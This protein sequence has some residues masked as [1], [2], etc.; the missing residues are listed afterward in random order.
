MVQRLSLEHRIAAEI[1]QYDGKMSIYANDLCG[2]EIIIGGKEKFETASTIKTFI[3]YTLFEK[4]KAGKVDLNDTLPFLEK[5]DV[6]GSGVLR[7]V[8]Y[9]G[10]YR[11]IDLATWMIIVSDNV[12]TNILI[13]FLGVEEINRSSMERGFTNTILHNPIDFDKYEKLGT[14]TVE[15]YG[16]FFTLLAKKECIDPVHDQMMLDIFEQQHYNSGIVGEF[17]VYYLDS[18]DT[19]EDELFKIYSKSGSMDACRND[20]GIIETPYGKYIIVLFT[21]EFSDPLYYDKHP[22]LLFQS[23]VSR[24]LFDQ[25]LALQGRF[26]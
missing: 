21:K 26:Q 10:K 12:A 2:N 7:S 4:V 16:K 8:P 17:P 5:H 11:I 13:D 18:E 1:H 14:T 24:L 6:E 20:G 9:G 15:D 23:K 22:S 3:L 19:G 25:Y